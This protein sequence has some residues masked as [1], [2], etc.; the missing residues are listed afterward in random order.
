MIKPLAIIFSTLIFIAPAEAFY[1]REATIGED[2]K[3]SA[4]VEEFKSSS[5]IRNAV[6]SPTTKTN[7]PGPGMVL[8]PACAGIHSRA[9]NDLK[10]WVKAFVDAGYTVLVVDHYQP[11]N[12]GKNCGGSRYR[13]VAEGRLVKDLYDAVEHLSKIPGVDKNRIFTFGLSLGTMVSGLA[14]SQD[15]YQQVADGRLRPRAVGGLYG[16]CDYGRGGKYL[17]NDTNIPVLW[18]MGSDD[19]ETPPEDCVPTLK[20]IEKKVKVDWHIYEGAGHCWDC[21]EL[22]GFKKQSPTGVHVTYLYDEKITNDSIKRSI[23]FY[24]SFK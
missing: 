1:G 20:V 7:K 21:K 5:F 8:L 15:V 3:F 6:F 14:A 13:T 17:F 18:L 12:A 22:H 16:G 23:D 10:V 4:Q 19:K 2:L 24:N 9:E 11:R